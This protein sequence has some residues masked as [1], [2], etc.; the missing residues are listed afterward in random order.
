MVKVMLSGNFNPLK[1]ETHAT[2]LTSVYKL[3]GVLSVSPEF[4]PQE[5]DRLCPRLDQALHHIWIKSDNKVQS[6]DSDCFLGQHV[7]LGFYMVC[8]H[9]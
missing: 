8:L 7:N 6:K 3:V 9:M 5:S 4:P 1:V 2:V